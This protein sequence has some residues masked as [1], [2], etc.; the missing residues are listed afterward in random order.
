LRNIYG[1]QAMKKLIKNWYYIS[2]YI[3]SIFTLLLALGDWS[4]T[5]KMIFASMIFI[6]LHFFEEFGFPGGFPWVGMKVELRIVDDDPRKWPLTNASAFWGNQWFAMAIYLLPLFLPQV[7]FLTLAVFVF[8]FF[9]LL[10]HLIVFN[11]ALKGLYN[12]GVLTTLFGLVPV[13]IVYLSKII[14]TGLY[15]WVDLGI[16]FVWIVLNYWVAFRS[17]IYNAIGKKTE[18]S[19]SEEE[20]NRAK[21][22]M[23]I[24]K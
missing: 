16:A 3:A 8:A 12:P 7:K 9:E 23:K 22:Y 18:Y 21:R 10:V 11:V 14:G 2:V 19:F 24:K 4:F 6:Q 15:S 17:P 13:S 1:G 20:V 5:Q